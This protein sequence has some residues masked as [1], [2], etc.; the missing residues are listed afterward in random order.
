MTPSKQPTDDDRAE[1]GRVA[2]SG[3]ATGADIDSVIDELRPLHPRNNL[4]PAELFL[5][6]A[7]DAIEESGASRTEPI[8][9]E[10]IRER[11]VPEVEFRGKAEHHKSHYAL[12]AAAMVRGGIRPDLLG[13]VIWWR[14]DDLWVFALLALVV[15]VRAAAER[16]GSTP[17]TIVSRIA[18]RRDLTLNVVL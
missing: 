5:E 15:Y 8:D 3:I 4:F 13:E 12:G 9:Y 16:T 7:A 10:G 6:L 2:L 1:A 14:A 18:A 11:W 17:A